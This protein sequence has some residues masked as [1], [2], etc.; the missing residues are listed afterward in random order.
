LKQGYRDVYALEGGWDAWVNAGYPVEPYDATP[1]D[2]RNGTDR[3]AAV[4]SSD[5]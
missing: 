3:M 4:G 2:L 5:E 1:E